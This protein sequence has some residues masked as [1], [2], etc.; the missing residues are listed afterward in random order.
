MAISTLAMTVVET[1]NTGTTKLAARGEKEP[2]F[3]LIRVITSLVEAA[4][5]TTTHGEVCSEV[6]DAAAL[7]QKTGRGRS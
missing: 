3:F 2:V 4:P 7:Q 5:T 6:A 1:A